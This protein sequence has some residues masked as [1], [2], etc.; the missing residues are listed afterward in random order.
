MLVHFEL[1][2]KSLAIMVLNNFPYS[3]S[4]SPFP[5][6]PALHLSLPI[7]HLLTTRCLLTAMLYEGVFSSLTA[8]RP[9]SLQLGGEGALN[10]PPWIPC[11]AQPPKVLVHF[12]V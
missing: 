12:E 7:T 5:F 10:L 8:S 4:K 3:C 1:E 11:E 2:L 9:H 6:I